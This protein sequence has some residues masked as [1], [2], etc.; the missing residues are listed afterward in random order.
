MVRVQTHDK[1]A[2]HTITQEVHDWNP[3]AAYHSRSWR[4]VT[5]QSREALLY[6]DV[7]EGDETMEKNAIGCFWN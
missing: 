3:M 2:R 6:D 5:W 4:N 7:M 1:Q